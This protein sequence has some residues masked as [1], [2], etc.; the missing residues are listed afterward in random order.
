M[1]KLPFYTKQKWFK[2]RN[3]LNEIWK[4]VLFGT[5]LSH[6]NYAPTSAVS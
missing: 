1:L 6:K 2:G 3:E 4:H 5:V